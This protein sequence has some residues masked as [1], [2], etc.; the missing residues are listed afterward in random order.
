[1]P[2]IGYD[3]RTA[4]VPVTRARI[5][6]DWLPT[7]GEERLRF[8]HLATSAD[9]NELPP[10]VAALLE[11]GGLALEP[12]AFHPSLLTAGGQ[13]RFAQSPDQAA[14]KLETIVSDID[15]PAFARAQA[16]TQGNRLDNLAV[17]SRVTFDYPPVPG[18]VPLG[19]LVYS[20]DGERFTVWAE[21]TRLANHFADRFPVY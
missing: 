17:E 12:V 13:L 1:M 10:P 15:V 3:G 20:L 18:L 14:Q 11:T 16:Q 6:T 7:G 5:V 21:G 19:K 8:S 4:M 2:R 9:P